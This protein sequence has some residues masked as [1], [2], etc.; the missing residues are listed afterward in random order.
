MDF[1]IEG[2]CPLC[3]SRIP[4]K[5][6][7]DKIPYF[8]E[9]L[10]ISSTCECGFRYSDIMLLSQ[11]EP[12]QYEFSVSSAEDLNTR[13]VRSSSGSIYIP[14]LG[15]DIEPGALSEAFIS[16]V[17]GVLDRVEEVVIVARSWVE[18]E[19][20]KR[21]AEE[22]LSKITAIKKGEKTM[23]LIIKDPLGNSAIVSDKA[24]KRALS[25]E[26]IRNLK[27][28]INIVDLQP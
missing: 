2:E 25:N 19:E 9:I 21:K 20:Q 14:E 18:T 8:E 6:Y 11:K 17:E 27:T 15:V 24:K 16:N 7:F 4:I 12:V 13:V 5:W 22:V 23:T 28:G 10:C 3:S 1:Q 26:E